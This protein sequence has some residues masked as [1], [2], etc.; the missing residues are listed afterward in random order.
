MS[1]EGRSVRSVL[2]V[3]FFVQIVLVALLLF[4]SIVHS[5]IRD[6]YDQAHYSKTFDEM[7]NYRIFLPRDYNTG[8]KY[9]PVIYWFHGFSGR[10]TGEQY[11]NG[12]V[13]LPE[14]LEFA[15]N[16][17]VII[18]KWDGFVEED[19]SRF[20]GG[21][22]YAVRDMESTMDFGSYFLELVA[23]TDSTF[24]T[25][26]DRQHRAV[27]G[28]SM[29]GFMSLYI[30]GRYPDM[31]GSASAFNPAHEFLVGPP[32][33]KALYKHV[34]HVRNHEHS[35]IRLV[36]ASGDYIG[37]YHD[38]LH[39]VYARTHE[40]DYEFSLDEYHRHWI[41]SIGETWG[42]HMKEF[43][44][45]GLMAHPKSWSYDT[46]WD[47]FSV[48][49]YDFKVENKKAGFVCLRDVGRDYFRITARQYCPDGP[50]ALDQT[51][52]ITTA[53]YYGNKKTYRIMDYSHADGS[54]V[55]FEI[56]STADGRLNIT[57]NGLGHDISVMNPGKHVR[58]PVL[59]PVCK[60]GT[61]I[62]ETEIEEH[63]S[64][65]LIN[66]CDVTARNTQVTLSSNYPTVEIEGETVVIE[67]MAPG[68]IVDLSDKFGMKFVSSDGDFSHV[69]LD[70]H[71]VFDGW[72]GS[73]ETIDVKVLPSPLIAPDS[74]VILDG[75]THSFTK[76]RQAG[77]QGGGAMYEREV[78]EGTGNGNGIAEPGEEITVWVRTVQ[79]LDALDK[80][81]WHRTKVYSKSPYV[82]ET[83]DMNENKERS[84][85][86]VKDHTSAVKISD[87][88]PNGSKIKLFLRNES[89][90]FYW[91]PDKRYGKELLYQAMH[92]FRYHV[93]GHTLSVGE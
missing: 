46:V 36:K 14:M 53:P 15:Q 88:C 38:E 48:W 51:I 43:D 61:P 69:R 11:E 77:N 63:L 62:V 44:N 68:E 20:Y 17:D 7:R 82:T 24:R 26:D 80:N 35:A 52:H 91:A 67:S 54:V 75:R 58:A 79:G 56:K 32:N 76:F 1:K 72:H 27:S 85:T 45:V 19:Y 86:G 65:R 39:E 33:K 18:V 6:F 60:S 50:P 47:E 87:D 73:D 81:S 3:S 74:I 21:A 40:V 66:T 78:T 89:Y 28:L 57:L 12:Q 9:Y 5:E 37:Q 8:G 42:F 84:F 93:T 10:H 70:M 41:T 55:F 92:F 25:L 30:S 23:H 2:P 49:G 64:L 22:P 59:L 13:F 34:N 29:G 71:I 83:Q 90:T 31:I 4:P 16:N